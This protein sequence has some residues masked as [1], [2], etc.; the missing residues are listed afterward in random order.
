MRMPLLFILAILS[1]VVSTASGTTSRCAS[2]SIEGVVTEVNA[3]SRSVIITAKDGAKTLTTNESTRFRIQGAPKEALRDRPL[4][5]IRT[6][7]KVKASYC[8]KDA[9][10]VDFRV[11][12]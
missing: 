4:S 2:R 10:L 5:L 9:T 7:A 3:D 6:D 1:P 11:L 8:I 12:K